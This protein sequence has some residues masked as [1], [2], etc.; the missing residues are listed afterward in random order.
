MVASSSPILTLKALPQAKLNLRLKITGRRVDG[1]HLLS[2]LV[3]PIDLRDE[4][5]VEFFKE[6]KTTARV[7]LHVELKGHC[8]DASLHSD[9]ANNLVFKAASSFIE[10]F[11][12]A[13]NVN[14]RL[15][16]NIPSGA[17]LGGGSSDAAHTLRLL[18]QACEQ[19]SGQPFFE[20][21]KPQ[22]NK[23]AGSLGSDVSF[24]MQDSPAIV[25]GVGEQVASVSLPGLAQRDA[26]LI[27]PPILSET[28]AAYTD[29][30]KAH[31]IFCS[32][33]NDLVLDDFERDRALVRKL[34]DNA[35]EK[36]VENDLEPM[37]AAR[38]PLIGRILAQL[39]AIPE[40]IAGLTGSGSA[41][42]IL[43]KGSKELEIGAISAALKR[44][45]SAM[46]VARIR[47]LAV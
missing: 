33:L 14:I 5:E 29:F 47:I 39:R 13:F 37:V 9:I 25:R 2:M 26:L 15:I 44:L 28:R 35:M 16:K 7:S 3:V 17:G 24:F 31:P 4:L 23:L 22:L 27:L 6:S 42:F 1:Y 18:A 19:I 41:C 32:E 8:H 36:V 20:G 45:D 43:S 40:A 38:F 34:D 21:N 12:P 10:R 30:Q 11:S 46:I